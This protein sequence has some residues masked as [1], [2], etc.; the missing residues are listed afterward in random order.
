MASSQAVSPAPVQALYPLHPLLLAGPAPAAPSACQTAA[1]NKRATIIE[2]SQRAASSCRTRGYSA[3]VRL[4]SYAGASPRSV[5]A[6]PV[7]LPCS[8]G[9]EQTDDGGDRQ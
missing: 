7:Q 5:S 2:A 9:G 4:T 3:G 6:K 8:G 1:F